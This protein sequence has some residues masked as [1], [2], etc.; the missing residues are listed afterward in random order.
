MEKSVTTITADQLFDGRSWIENARLERILPPTAPTSDCSAT[1][2]IVIPGMINVHSHAFQFGFA[3]LAESQGLKTDN[4]WT[5]RRAMYSFLES[6]GPDEMY[7]IAADVYARMLAAGYSAVGEFHYVHHD[8]RGIPYQ[9]QTILADS[10]IR[11][12]LDTGIRICLLFS[13]YNRGGF[14]GSPLEG[15]QRRFG[16]SPQDYLAAFEQLAARWKAHDRVLLGIAPHSL[17]AADVCQIQEV[18]AAASQIAPSCPIH[19]HVAEQQ[20]E[21]DACLAHTG[22]R[23]GELLLEHVD[24]DQRWCLIHGTHLSPDEIQRLTL[25]GV[26]LGLCPTTEGNLG[27]G[28]FAADTWAACGGR[29]AIGSDSQVTLNPFAELRQLEYSQ[30]LRKKARVILANA[31]QSN[32]RWLFENAL[33]GGQHALG[34]RNNHLASFA[35]TTWIVIAECHPSQAR[36]H[37]KIFDSL[38]FQE[39]GPTVETILRDFRCCGSSNMV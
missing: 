38:V 4:F 34:W 25:Q 28:I 9:D 31:S 24:L 10:I 7:R 29:I 6:L 27:D 16:Y 17:R 37:D 15:V 2:R 32:G 30:R 1:A 11:A 14:D 22:L 21:V 5:W 19:M 39:V 23:P 36:Q 33:H 8:P 35:E 18:V 20:A 13:Y 3:G 12:A 26:T